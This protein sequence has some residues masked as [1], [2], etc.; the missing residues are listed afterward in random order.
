MAL[1]SMAECPKTISSVGGNGLAWAHDKLVTDRQL[2]HGEP[3]FDAVGVE[4]GHV[5][6]SHCRQRAQRVPGP[7][8]GPRLEI[9]AGQEEGG[10]ANGNVDVDGTT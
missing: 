9:S 3:V 6:G 5:L 7:A 10:H 8:L 4:H 2:R 1:R